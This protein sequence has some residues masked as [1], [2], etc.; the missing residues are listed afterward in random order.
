M[1]KNLLSILSHVAH[2]YVGNRACV[3]P[4]QCCGWDVDA[5]N[6]TDY[7]NHPGH[8]TFQGTKNDDKF[9]TT[10]FNGL[11]RLYD[12]GTYYD[13]ILVGYCPSAEV[14]LAVHKE[15]RPI[16][17]ETETARQRPLLVMDPVLGD[18]GRLYVPEEVVQ[19]HMD[20][21]K[22][23]VVDLTTPNQFEMELLTGITMNTWEDV[24]RSMR[25]FHELYRVKNFVI[26]SAFVDGRMYS[27]GFSATD[28]QVFCIPIEEIQCRF[29]GC[30]DV[31]TALL[32]DE[33][34]ANDKIFT[35][36]VLSLVLKKLHQILI[37]SYQLEEKKLGRKPEVV[38]DIS[39]VALRK[40]FEQSMDGTLEV[41]YL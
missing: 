25:L 40:I 41:K 18:N 33:F 10:I 30:G 23:G 24:K 15:L 32:T 38:N 2:G 27:V 37:T 13:A 21:L 3:F 6:T 5:V 29:S 8:G 16:Y 20:F 17:S 34:Y 12:L 31:F 1:T 35:P 28:Q 7:L 19:V 9:I 22:L 4:L 39:L 14:M 26:L 36:T 11:R